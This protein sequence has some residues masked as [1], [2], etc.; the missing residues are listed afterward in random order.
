MVT[1]SLGGRAGT[2]FNAIISLAF[3]G[4]LRLGEYCVTKQEHHCYDVS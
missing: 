2:K 1:K 3:F 4:L